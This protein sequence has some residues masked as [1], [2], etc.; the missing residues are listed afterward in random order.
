MTHE[1]FKK[2]LEDELEEIKEFLLKKNKAYGNSALRPVRIFSKAS[3]VE[4][5][6]VRLDDKVSRLMNGNEYPG[7]DDE[8]DI[9]GYLILKRMAKSEDGIQD[10]YRK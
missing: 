9:L 3:P 1:Q 2:M 5:I 6:N 10:K 8:L 7:D 4:Q